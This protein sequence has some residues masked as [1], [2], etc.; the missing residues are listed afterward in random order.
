MAHGRVSDEYIHFLLMYTTDTVFP[1]IPIIK[2]LNRDDEQ[3]TP[4]TL[5]TGKKLQY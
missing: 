1:V 3:T 2:I 5:A 4:Q